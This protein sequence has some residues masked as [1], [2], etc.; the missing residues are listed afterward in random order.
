MSDQEE[1]KTYK[2]YKEYQKQYYQNNRERILEQS[3]QSRTPEKI[4]KQSNYF[5]E[6]YRKN[7]FKI[8][9]NN[10]DKYCNKNGG[11]I[12]KFY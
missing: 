4:M 11:G 10:Q 7:K 1:Q 12:V 6:Y 9:Y 8:N 5:K 2:Y 3:K